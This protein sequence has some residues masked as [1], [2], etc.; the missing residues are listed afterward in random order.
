M[1]L[2][3]L[4]LIIEVDHNLVFVQY[5]DTLGAHFSTLVRTMEGSL[6]NTDE[7]TNQAQLDSPTRV[8]M[9]G[10]PGAG[11]S[12]LLNGLAG[13]AVFNSGLSFKG[14]VTLVS[15]AVTASNGN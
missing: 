1:W 12:T 8:I 13:R 3:I 9:L 5:L 14:S 6:S 10:N 15:Q 11:K 2:Q 7:P 4:L